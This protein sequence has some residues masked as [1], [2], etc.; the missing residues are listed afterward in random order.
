[1]GALADIN[2][3]NYKPTRNVSRRTNAYAFDDC[4]G[5]VMLNVIFQFALGTMVAS[6]GKIYKNRELNRNSA[7]GVFYICCRCILECFHAGMS[8][9]QVKLF[10]F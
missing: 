7:N 10:F 1:M 4:N 5:E 3:S 2:K 8:S 9:E 6:N